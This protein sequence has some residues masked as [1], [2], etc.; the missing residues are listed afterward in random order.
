MAA[1]LG[2]NQYGKS[3]IRIV[4]VDRA[5][6]SDQIRD[7]S[8]R[9]TLKGEF[10]ASYVTGDNASI[11]PTDSQKNAVHAFAARGVG[12]IEDLA[13]ELAGFFVDSQPTVQEARVDIEEREWLAAGTEPATGRSAFLAAGDAVRRAAVTR[14][15]EGTRVVSG[16]SGLGLMKCGGS[17]FHGFVRDR[18]TTLAEASDRILATEVDAWWTYRVDPPDWSEAYHA[19]RRHLVDAF[20]DTHSLA[21]QQTLFAMGERVLAHVPEID[22]VTLEMPNRH[23]F[24]VDLTPFAEAGRVEVHTV[25]PAPYGLIQGTVVR[26]RD[27]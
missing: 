4:T 5:G 13:R 1:V 16:L 11:L 26:D 21:L 24:P 12:A 10:A 9:T 14:G 2:S 17:E 23:H 3:G 25:S 22:S 20:A 19:A 8:V 7:L 18:Y 6:R 15:P 27:T